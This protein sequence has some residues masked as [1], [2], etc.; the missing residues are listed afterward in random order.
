MRWPTSFLAA[1]LETT[2]HTLAAIRSGNAGAWL[3]PWTA[4]CTRLAALLLASEQRLSTAH[5]VVLRGLDCPAPGAS[6]GDVQVEAGR[7]VR[8]V[9][10][11]RRRAQGCCTLLRRPTCRLISSGGKEE[12]LPMSNLTKVAMVF[13]ARTTVT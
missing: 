5:S 2:P 11:W 10:R 8:P 3:S 13:P 6:S 4:E 9:S 12:L 1:R 7:R